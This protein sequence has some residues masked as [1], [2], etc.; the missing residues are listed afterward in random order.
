MGPGDVF[1]PVA[2]SGVHHAGILHRMDGVVSLPLQGPVPSALP[3]AAQA[4]A[5]L[6]REMT[7]AAA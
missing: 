2:V 7:H 6:Q 4:L 1:I 5:A 3:S